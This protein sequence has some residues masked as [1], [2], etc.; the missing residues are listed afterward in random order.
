MR[1]NQTLPLA[2]DEMLSQVEAAQLKKV[3]FRGE[4]VGGVSSYLAGW[5]AGGGIDVIVLDGANGFDPY[6]VS[7][8]ARKAL[9]PPEKLLKQIRIARAFTCYQMAALVDKLPALFQSD[10]GAA[11]TFRPRVI[12]LGWVTAFL[13]ED[14]PEREVRPL[15][16]RSLRRVEAMAEEGIPFFFFQAPSLFAS[17]RDYL[18]KRLSQVSNLVLK[19]SLEDG[20]P[21]LVLEKG[22]AE[23]IGIGKLSP[24]G[25]D[26]TD[27][28]S[29]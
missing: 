21:K 24:E 13:D 23:Q 27:G 8:F 9:I 3:L 12:L 17:K 1:M 10:G 6:R 4:R 18:M 25:L 19:V 11:R 20:G 26:G 16:E 2:F 22:P 15:F 29:V 28:P 14:V 5:M 7:S